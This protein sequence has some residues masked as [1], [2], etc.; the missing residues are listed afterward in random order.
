MR[1][2]EADKLPTSWVVKEVI[3]FCLMLALVALVAIIAV[4]AGA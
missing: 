3:K 1:N 4:G 2:Y